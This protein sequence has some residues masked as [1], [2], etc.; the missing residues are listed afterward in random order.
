VAFVRRKGKAYYLV[1]NVRRRGKVRQ[2]HLARLGG[3]PRITDDVMRQVSKNHPL[4]ELDWRQLREQV[5]NHVELFDFRSPYLQNLVDS[6][7]ALNLDLAEL[8]LP[9]VTVSDQARSSRELVTQL[10]LLRTTVDI[11]LG[12]LERMH[13]R[14]IEGGRKLR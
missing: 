2:L 3:R 6:L 4:L 12:Q 9:L 14:G 13:P 5:N 7:R 10:R 1:H 8:S 11:K